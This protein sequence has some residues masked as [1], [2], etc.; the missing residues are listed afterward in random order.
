[1]FWGRYVFLISRC[2]RTVHGLENLP[3]HTNIIYIGNHQSYADI[4][5]L[6]ASLPTTV[7]FVAKKELSKVPILGMWMRAVNCVFIDRGHLRQAMRDLE[8]GIHEASNG[9]PMAIFPE[10][11]RSR[12][13]EMLPFKP[14]SILLAAKAGLTIVPVTINGTYKV[15][16]EQRKI[17]SAELELTIHPY[18]DTKDMSDEEKKGLTERL[19]KT[20]NSAL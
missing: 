13:A 15:Y 4:P 20:I 8:K 19:W 5:F 1:M 6:M 16:E 9:Y 2:R 7:G 14:G 12:T 17:V 18:I 11:T 10:G 3:D